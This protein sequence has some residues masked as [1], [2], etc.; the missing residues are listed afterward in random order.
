MLFQK[1]T[2]K[3]IK[4]SGLFAIVALYLSQG[5]GLITVSRLGDGF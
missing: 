5:I 3:L 2:V 1:K 4:D